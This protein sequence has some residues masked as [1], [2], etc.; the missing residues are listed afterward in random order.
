MSF[1]CFFS[2]H[3]DSPASLYPALLKAVEQHATEY[4]VTEVLVGNYGAFD[5]M[6]ARAVAEVKQAHPTVTL[7]LTLLLPYHPAERKIIL[8]N[9]TDGTLY[10]PD[11]ENVPRKLAILRANHYAVEHADYLIAYVRRPASNTRELLEYAHRK[12]S[13]VNITLL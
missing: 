11:M 5:H 7:T 1:I 12:N 10:P 3:R 4:G 2:G 13:R 9:E 6:A 8:P